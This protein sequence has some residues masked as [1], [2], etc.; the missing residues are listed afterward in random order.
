[1]R[2]PEDRSRLDARV[3]EIVG[4]VLELPLNERETAIEARSAD[5]E[6]ADRVR[7]VVAAAASMGAFMARPLIVADAEAGRQGLAAEARI[8]GYRVVSLIGSG[9]MGDVYSAETV[10]GGDLV[11]LKIVR[12]GVIPRE[13]RR[14]FEFEIAA[15]ARLHHPNIARLIDSGTHP[16]EEGDRLFL[17]MELVRG[18]TLVEHARDCAMDTDDR[19]KLFLKVCDAIAHAHRSGIIHRDLK[20]ANILVDRETEEPKVLDFGVAR[21]A[22][23]EGTLSSMPGQHIVGSLAYMSPEQAGGTGCGAI[24]T[25]TDVY[26]LGAVLYELIAGVPPHQPSGQS[27]AEFLHLVRDHEPPRLGKM[28]ASAPEELE[29]VVHAAIARD[30]RQRYQSVEALASDLH[31][32]LKGDPLTIRPPR[33]AYLLWRLAVRHKT[34]VTLAVVLAIVLSG[35][36]GFGGVQ[37]V[38][39]RRAEGRA[40]VLLHQ[41]IEATRTMLVDVNREMLER[42]QPLESR[43]I[44][45]EGATEYL[46]RVQTEVSGD[47]RILAEVMLAYLRLGGIIGGAGDSS[48]GD[49]GK[50]AALFA[51]AIE[52]GRH[53][54][55]V[56]ESPK[57]RR[58][59]AGA[60]EET[61]LLTTGATP[62][63]FRE[64]AEHLQHAA[65]SSASDAESEHDERSALQLLLRA[66]TMEEN[67]P[68]VRAVVAEIQEFTER[69]A[70]D[71]GLWSELGMAQ[72]FLGELHTANQPQEALACFKESA[73]SFQRSVTLG[74][75]DFT[76]NRHLAQLR[77]SMVCCW[78]GSEPAETLLPILE[79]ALARSSRAS[80]MLHWT[81]FANWSHRQTIFSVLHR[82]MELAE[83]P[84]PLG[85]LLTPEAI[86]SRVLEL[87][88]RELENMVPEG[89]AVSH[90]LEPELIRQ[91]N[92]AIERLVRIAAR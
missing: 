42:G 84:A 76:N 75:D 36:V 80:G 28:V 37:L 19:V 10:G 29:V 86:A 56:D 6:L 74:H 17:V 45:L 64:A 39:A 20:P 8:G 79:E 1:M 48:L 22:D 66:A 92:I 32:Y 33:A 14:R 77:V 60:L 71:A 7:S 57:I 38:R 5:S 54:L 47:P 69:R 34:V 24:D 30:P 18:G 44:A 46:D 85:Q 61:A 87:S 16:G 35:A 62:A 50:A 73:S 12:A 52:L 72:R 89:S 25:R 90:P 58:L 65:G 41:V 63:L 3:M 83:A 68:A 31:R 82:G 23:T 78:A 49:S 27:L 81:N 59:M 4:H 40:D 26:A 15:L 43:L 70:N 67:V 55:K 9:S 11:A 21:A 88:R 53:L 51:K 13:L 2:Q 91:I